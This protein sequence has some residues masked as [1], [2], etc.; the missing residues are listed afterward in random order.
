L[1]FGCYLLLV[2]VLITRAD[3]MNISDFLDVIIPILSKWQAIKPAS[4]SGRL[5]SHLSLCL[6]SY[7]VFLNSFTFCLLPRQNLFIKSPTSYF[8]LLLG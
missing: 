8:L 3:P 6:L 1:T 2:P 5:D 7:C 4:I